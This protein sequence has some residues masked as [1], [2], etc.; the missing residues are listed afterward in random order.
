MARSGLRRLL[1]PSAFTAVMLAALLALGT[2]QLQRRAWKTALLADIDR[3]EAAPAIALP[4]DPRPFTKVYADGVLRED[5]AAL[6]GSELRPTAAG[7]T[8]GAHLLTPL[9]RPDADPVIVDRGWVPAD[10]PRPTAPAAGPVRVE[11]YVRA[12]EMPILFGAKDDPL[13]RRFFAL[14]PAAIGASFGLPRTAP[15]TLIALGA[16]PPN[17][18]PVPARQMPRPSN[19]HLMYAFTWYGLA[20]ALLAVFAV[21]CRTVL[22]REIPP[23]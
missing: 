14:D 12:P 17:T 16:A 9:E 10:R 4:P 19:N 8:L 1:W 2:W 20:G 18:Y 13:A 22:R 15:F 5:L 23:A 7:P 11:G 6:Y 21:Y 3:G